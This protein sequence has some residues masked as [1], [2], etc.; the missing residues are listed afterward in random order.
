V[1]SL[2]AKKSGQMFTREDV[3]L[4]RTL[5]AQSAIALEN[6]RLFEDLADSLKQVHMLQTIK[7][8]LAK[9]VPR[10]VQRLLESSPDAEGLF[11]KRE[12]DLS[13]VFA[14]MTGYT[15]MSAQLPLDEV[16][17]IVERYFGAFLD[18]ILAHG[19]DVNETAGDGLMVLFM[20]DDPAVHARAA[21]SAALD[22]QRVTREINGRRT[23]ELPIGM[24]VGVNSG[25]ASVGA[26]KIEGGAGMR[27][28]YT[29]SGPTT[30]IAARMAALGQDIA[31][32]EATRQRLGE[33]FTLESLGPQTL[34]NVA[35]PVVSYRVLARNG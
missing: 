35:Q 28:T 23:G 30:N 20:D 19:G 6:A 16:N 7:T 34:K 2:G 4:L 14:D 12:R 31:V 1:L 25:I 13:V 9:F 22:I 8:S 17:A 29:A 32:T 3:D 33:E 24:H 10:T 11:D 27:W 26:T 21:V 18:V 5:L 15:R